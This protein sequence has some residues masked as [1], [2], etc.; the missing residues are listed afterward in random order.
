MENQKKK[1]SL[2]DIGNLD[3][4]E[5]QLIYYIRTRFRYGEIQ[6]ECRDGKPYRIKKAVE[7]QTID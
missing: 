3:D 7:Y 5:I 2:D 6:I 1:I 4:Q